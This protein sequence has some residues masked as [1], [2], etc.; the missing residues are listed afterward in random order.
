ME[1]ADEIQILIAQLKSDVVQTAKNY[2]SLLSDNI[3]R[4]GKLIESYKEELKQ[5]TKEEKHGNS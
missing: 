3:I 4:N 5:I 1:R 2:P